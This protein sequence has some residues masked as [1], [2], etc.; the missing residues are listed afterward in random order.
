MLVVEVTV[1]MVA[2][3]HT[4]EGGGLLV[5]GVEASDAEAKATGRSSS[6]KGYGGIIAQVKKHENH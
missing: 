5:L 4:Y 6:T 3:T 2:G 1:A